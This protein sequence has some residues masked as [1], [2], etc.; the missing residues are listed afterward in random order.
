MPEEDLH[1][2][3]MAPLQAHLAGRALRGPSER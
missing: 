1:L 2:S 3:D